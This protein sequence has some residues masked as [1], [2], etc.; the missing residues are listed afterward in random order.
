MVPAG[1]VMAAESGQ[2]RA[3]RFRELASHH[4]AKAANFRRMA[5]ACDRGNAGEVQIA[6][7]LDTLD[8]AGWR[9]LNDRYKSKTS[10][11][12]LDHVVIG[13][14]GVSVIDTKNW[15]AGRIR[16][17][18]RGMGLGTGARTT[19]SAAAPRQLPSS[20]SMCEPSPRQPQRRVSWR[21]PVTSAYLSRCGTGTSYFCSVSTCCRGWSPNRRC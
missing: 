14:G 6:S 2:R 5:E 10:P 17:D 18:D 1:G 15:S 4:E 11:T 7:L 20:R 16:L 3:Q 19:S 12:N 13:P 9:V 21:S 8:G